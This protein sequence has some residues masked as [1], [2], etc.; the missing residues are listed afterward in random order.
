M[1]G[2]TYTPAPGSLACR[3]MGFLERQED[4][5]AEF[6]TAVIADALG[7]PATSIIPA[8]D[9]A[10]AA[11][12]VFNRKKGGHMRSPLFWSLVDHSASPAV[13]LP[14]WTAPPMRHEPEPTIEEL[15]GPLAGPVGVGLLE[16]KPIAPRDVDAPEE[17]LVGGFAPAFVPSP[18]VRID[19]TVRGV[20][21]HEAERI[22][23]FVQRMR[24]GVAA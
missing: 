4:R 7:V 24:A 22:Q 11:G 19:V 17:T 8:L 1:K 2:S 13:A 16:P 5:T 21:L 9:A 23:Q 6:S 3:V 12:T 10:L 14:G 20:S 18:D 15:V